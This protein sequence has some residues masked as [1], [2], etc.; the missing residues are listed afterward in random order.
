MNQCEYDAL[1]SFAY[2]VAHGKT[3]ESSSWKKLMSGVSPIAGNRLC[4]NAYRHSST[5]LTRR[6]RR[7]SSWRTSSSGASAS[8]TF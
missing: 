5:P 7:A 6:R 8:Y 4:K 2:N 3:G 1:T